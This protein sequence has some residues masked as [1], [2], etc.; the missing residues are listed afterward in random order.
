MISKETKK[1][2]VFCDSIKDMLDVSIEILDGIYPHV[3]VKTRYLRCVID[4]DDGRIMIEL[5]PARKEKTGGLCPH[6]IL[7]E[8]NDTEFI[9]MVRYSI[10]TKY[11][12]IELSSIQELM[13]LVI[14]LT[15]KEKDND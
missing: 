13:D 12:S 7:F 10:V 5:R 14:K 1:V 3:D 9:D 11:N 8:T 6:Y 2:I 4:V 15:A